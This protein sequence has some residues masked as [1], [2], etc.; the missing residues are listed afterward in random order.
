VFIDL[1]RHHRIRGV[2]ERVKKA[3]E[4]MERLID[5]LKTINYNL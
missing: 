4:D 3:V 5:R 1:I 2:K